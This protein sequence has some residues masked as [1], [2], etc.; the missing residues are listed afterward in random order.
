MLF[1]EIQRFFDH[2]GK[3]I[4]DQAVGLHQQISGGKELDTRL[5]P[6]AQSRMIAYAE[7]PAALAEDETAQWSIVFELDGESLA[8][9]FE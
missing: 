3:I 2:V 1:L 4:H 9:D 8:V 7:I 6:M 5:L